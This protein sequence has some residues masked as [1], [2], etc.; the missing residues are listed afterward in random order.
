MADPVVVLSLEDL[1]AQHAAALD[2][3]EVARAEHAAAWR[4]WDTTGA[5]VS[6][7]QKALDKVERAILA[8]ISDADPEA[9][10]SPSVYLG[11]EVT[12]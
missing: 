1:I 10:G 7:R 8:H 5:L 9:L 6:D 3:L 11:P 4:V 12:S 2:L